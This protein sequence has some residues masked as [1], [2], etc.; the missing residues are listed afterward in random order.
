MK[1]GTRTFIIVALIVAAA[2]LLGTGIYL[3]YGKADP[4]SVQVE[5]AEPVQLP[6]LEG[7]YSV[8][9]MAA[10][11]TAIFTCQVSRFAENDYQIYLV[12]EKG[13]KYFSFNVNMLGGMFSEELGEGEFEY[14]QT[15][16]K[17][18][19]TFKKEEN[20]CVLTK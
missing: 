6:D 12:T 9:L 19:I 10:D 8:K 13:P 18:T 15:L 5:S 7:N 17:I 1:N 2:S 14:N 3:Y 11:T 4:E 16:D 20:I